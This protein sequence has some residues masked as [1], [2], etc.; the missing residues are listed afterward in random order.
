MESTWEKQMMARDNIKIDL[1][2]MGH[3]DGNSIRVSSCSIKCG[4]F[5]DHL[6]GYQLLKNSSME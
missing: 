6:I 1:K 3:K 2:E 4:E 5:L